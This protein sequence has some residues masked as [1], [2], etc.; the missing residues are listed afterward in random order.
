MGTNE[1]YEATSAM[2]GNQLLINNKRI[3]N[4]SILTT[5]TVTVI[6]ATINLVLYYEK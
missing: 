6:V 1:T 5:P 4:V 3:C 2:G